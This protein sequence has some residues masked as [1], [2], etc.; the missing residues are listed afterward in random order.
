MSTTDNKSK[1][2]KK[3]TSTGNVIL[4]AVLAGAIGF[5]AAHL[6]DSKSGDIIDNNITQEDATRYEYTYE[7]E[8]VN[9]E[10]PLVVEDVSVAA[11]DY[12]EIVNDDV[13]RI[14]LEARNN[15]EYLLLMQC[16]LE[17]SN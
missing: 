13:Y 17:N 9:Y 14:L 6:A 2:K 15:F 4:I 5:G 1:N 12:Y 3:A 7:E 11:A 10:E 16:Q 8:E